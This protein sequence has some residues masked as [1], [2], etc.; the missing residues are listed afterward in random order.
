MTYKHN[1]PT[2]LDART[3]SSGGLVLLRGISEFGTEGVTF[4]GIG[5]FSQMHS[6]VDSN[7]ANW[8]T[9]GS[10]YLSEFADAQNWTTVSTTTPAVLELAEE[11][12]PLPAPSGEAAGC[13]DPFSPACITW[14]TDSPIWGEYTG[15]PELVSI[16]EGQ[17]EPSPWIGQAPQA[18]QRALPAT[19]A[20]APGRPALMTKQAWR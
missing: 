1:L 16:P 6:T 9:P 19:S 2:S 18:A 12:M 11:P 4:R 15:T 14:Q 7:F 17:P 13:A 20:R 3:G 8:G 10:Q 5:V